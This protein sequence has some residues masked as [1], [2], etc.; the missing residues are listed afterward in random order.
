MTKRILFLAALLGVAVLAAGCVGPGVTPGKTGTVAVTLTSGPTMGSSGAAAAIS[1]VGTVKAA[2]IS[3]TSKDSFSAVSAVNVTIDSVLA[4]HDELGWQT[5]RDKA[6]DPPLELNLLDL[7]TTKSVIAQNSQMPSGHYS[8]LKPVLSKVTI[9]LANNVSIPIDLPGGNA[10]ISVAVDALVQDGAIARL[11]INF[12]AEHSFDVTTGEMTP[13]V[14]ADDEDEVGE[15]EGYVKPYEEGIEV[16][17]LDA[18]GN[19][20]A[21]VTPDDEDGE[22][23]FHLVEP[24]TYTIKVAWP[25]TGAIEFGGIAVQAGEESEIGTLNADGTITQPPADYEDDD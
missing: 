24:G 20:V 22:F 9:V 5:V 4:K 18:A 23:E 8:E 16:K 3:A 12:D 6:V 11:I 17:L 2:S 1:A 25:S 7:A 14:T 15:I 10:E 21:A 13:V 19:E